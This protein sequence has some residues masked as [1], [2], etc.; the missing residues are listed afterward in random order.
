M[1]VLLNMLNLYRRSA[2]SYRLLKFGTHSFC[3]AFLKI[4]LSKKSFFSCLIPVLKKTASCR[5]CKS[6][7][8]VS[9]KRDYQTSYIA[10]T[11]V[12]GITTIATGLS[13]RL[14]FQV[15]VSVANNRFEPSDKVSCVVID[16]ITIG[17]PCC[18]HPNCPLPLRNQRDRF[19]AAHADKG[20]ICAI[21]GCDQPIVKDTLTCKDPVHQSV[22]NRARQHNQAFFQ[23]HHRLQTAAQRKAHVEEGN[24]EDAADLVTEFDV[25]QAGK[26]VP[27]DEGPAAHPDQPQAGNKRLKAQFGRQRSHNEQIIVAP[28]GIIIGR[29]TFFGAEGLTSVAVRSL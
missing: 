18:S 23:L 15:Y 17:H 2:F 5:P 10:V 27:E 25:N 12:R 8:S 13:V 11:S 14:C 29:V 16:G 9:S 21:K 3:S 1:T 7:M 26:V 19:C 4:Q 28:C 24:E 20:S 22:E 6:V